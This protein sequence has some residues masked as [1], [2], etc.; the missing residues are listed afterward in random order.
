MVRL[1]E[2]LMDLNRITHGK[3]G[4]RKERVQLSAVVNNAIETCNPLIEQM[5][6]KLTITIPKEPIVLD[7]D[8]TRLS[9]VFMNLLNNAAKYTERGGNIRLIAKRESSYVLVSVLDTGI[10]IPPDKLQSIFGMFSQIDHALERSQGGLGIGLML[11]KKLLEL[12]GG[13]VEAR[14]SGL[15]TGSEFIVRLPVVPSLV[16]QT[17]S[18]TDNATTPPKIRRQILVVDD[19]SD[20]A[21]SLAMLLQ[22]MGHETRTANDGLQALE[23][24]SAFKPDVILLD[25]GMPKL[26]GYE[27]CRRIREQAWGRIA[28]LVACTG[29]G[30]DDYKHKAFEAGFNLHMVKPVD[31]EA[32][33]KLLATLESAMA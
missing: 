19:N 16:D 31:L 33:E 4:L 15:G 23:V 1:V 13:S 30:Q 8:M 27:T 12:H 18:V 7:A 28:L 21:D 10:G 14:S 3:I 2:D 17:R 20:S 24:G 25:I 22:L 11:V 6:H 9:Q 32:L 5:G 29:W 26:N